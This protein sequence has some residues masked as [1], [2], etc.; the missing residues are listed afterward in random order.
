MAEDSF[1]QGRP[2]DIAH[3]NKQ[4][5]DAFHEETYER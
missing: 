4:D 2:A 3:A 5:A 1:R